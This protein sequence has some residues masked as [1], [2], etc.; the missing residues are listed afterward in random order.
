MAISTPASGLTAAIPAV[1]EKPVVSEDF[2]RHPRKRK[3]DWKQIGLAALL[4][5]P[6]LLLLVLFTYRP[7]V[8]NIRISFF[9]W[10]ISS[11]TMTF[12]GLQN[13]IDWFQAPDTGRVVFNT[14][15]F[16]FFAVAG[17]MVLGLA[18]A[19]LLDQKLFGRA[20]VR[21]MVFAPYVIA[22]AA[23]G[24]AFQ[25]VFDPNYGLIQYLLGIIGVDVP[26]FY[27]QQNWALFMI[28]VTYIWK[29]VGYVFVI[30]L[31]ALQGRR[32]DLDEASEIDGTPAA[33][34]FF[35]V[36]LPQLRGTTFFLLITVLLN[37]FQV[38]DIINA[39]T[40]GGPFGY[41]TSTM[42]F[43]V[44]QETFINNRAGYGAAVATI[45]F[46]VVLVITVLQIKLQE[47]MDK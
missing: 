10:N 43:Q 35:R 4:V 28:T 1:T 24:V 31:A 9:N 44:Y 2:A 41:G 34:H 46:L 25:F 26:N 40:G 6:N 33:R 27:Q 42:V 14:V 22:G 21:S 16:T 8:D 29:N 15:V 36:V 12:V 47:R 11:P 39:M 38:F 5:G 18:L 13:Y 3:L 30:Y 17:S 32:R 19:L 20:A 23:I 7:L 37:S 45:M